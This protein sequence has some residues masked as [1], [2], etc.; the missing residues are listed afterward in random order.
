MRKLRISNKSNKWL[1]ALQPVLP[2]WKPMQQPS[3]VDPARQ[4]L[5]TCLVR[6]PAPQ[7]LGPSGPMALGH[8]MTIGIQD[9][10]LIPPQALRMN[11]REVP[12]YYGS[13]VNNTTLELRSGSIIFS[14]NPTCQQTTDLLQFIVQAGSLSARLVLETRAKCQD[15]VARYKY[16]GIPYAIDSPFCSDT[17]TIT[18]R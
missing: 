3:P 7:P 9:A 2:H 10:D 15:S 8:P 11:M 14:K 17:T 1:A 16:D 18:V 6:V 13:L 4:D 5:G 12:S